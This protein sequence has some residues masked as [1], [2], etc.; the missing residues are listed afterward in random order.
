[1]GTLRLRRPQNEQTI[2]W[3]TVAAADG[4][5]AALDAVD[6]AARI[7]STICNTGGHAFSVQQDQTTV[8][9]G[10]FNPM[11]ELIILVP[12]SMDTACPA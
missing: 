5:A 1:M 7:F 9:L 4:E 11:L 2:E 8:P 3:N 10:C 12:A 6:E